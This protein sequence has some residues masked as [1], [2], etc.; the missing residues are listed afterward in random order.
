MATGSQ[1]EVQPPG[2]GCVWLSPQAS[3]LPTALPS[4]HHRL[5]VPA[6]TSLRLLPAHS[7]ARLPGPHVQDTSSPWRKAQVPI[8]SH[9]A[10]LTQG[11]LEQDI[12]SPWRSA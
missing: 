12:P 2:P 6:A 9:G 11:G 8:I 10:A 7:S 4:L 5:L 3:S 1:R